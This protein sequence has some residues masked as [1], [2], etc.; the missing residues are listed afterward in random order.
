MSP[1]VPTMYDVIFSVVAIAALAFALVAFVSILRTPVKSGLSL[2][3]WSLAVLV[4]PV[5]GPIAWF[6]VGRSTAVTKSLTS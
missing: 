5:L 3:G 6:K 2:I 4:I 1:L